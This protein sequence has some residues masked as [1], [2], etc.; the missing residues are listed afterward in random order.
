ML[1]VYFCSCIKRCL[2]VRAWKIW[3]GF[4]SSVQDQVYGNYLNS[5]YVAYA[6]L[7]L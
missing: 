1:M 3:Q 5:S 7:N 4:L 2:N 6:R